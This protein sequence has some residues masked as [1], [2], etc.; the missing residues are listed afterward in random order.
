VLFLYLPQPNTHYDNNKG[1]LYLILLQP[2]K[3]PLLL[4]TMAVAVVCRSYLS[5]S[6]HIPLKTLLL[7]I[8]TPL[9]W[10]SLRFCHWQK[11]QHNCHFFTCFSLMNIMTAIRVAYIQ[12]CSNQG[13]K[14]STLTVDCHGF[15]CCFCKATWTPLNFLKKVLT[16]IKTHLHWQR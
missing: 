10:Q 8:N 4:I 14:K 3:G 5:T 11:Y 13:T 7:S 15:C 2:W 6:Q 12:F 16:T 9:H 1:C